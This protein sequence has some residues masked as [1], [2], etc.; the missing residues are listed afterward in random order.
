MDDINIKN[1]EVK[2]Q[3]ICEVIKVMKKDLKTINKNSKKTIMSIESLKE[4][5][6]K[7]G[8]QNFKLKRQ[9]EEKNNDEIKIYKKIIKMLDLIDIIY[10]SAIALGDK[11]FIK[12]LDIINKI[13]RKEMSEINLVEI[14]SLGE[15]FNPVLHK[16]VAVENHKKEQENQI[17][18]V[19][20]KGYMLRGKVV[21][22][23]SVIISR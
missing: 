10:E 19:I 20:E 11:E 13:I 17:I 23:S 7:K 6:N 21:R 16:C 8:E 3:Q 5:V 9:L 22:P 4:D 2:L 15:L 14:K 18:S 12:N 1:E